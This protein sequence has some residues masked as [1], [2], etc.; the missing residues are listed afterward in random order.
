MHFLIT[1]ARRTYAHT[2]E[3]LRAAG[4]ADT[5]SLWAGLLAATKAAASHGARVDLTSK[6]RADMQRAARAAADA[7]QGL[8]AATQDAESSAAELSRS[9]TQL[10]SKRD[11][12]VRVRACCGL[13]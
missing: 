3:P 11:A 13:G 6:P 4:Y 1:H 9:R 7:K 5:A 10:E 12:Q 2:T 8:A